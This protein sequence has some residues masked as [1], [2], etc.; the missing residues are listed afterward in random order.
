MKILKKLIWEGTKRKRR[1][2]HLLTERIV[3][4]EKYFFQYLKIKLEKLNGNRWG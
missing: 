4:I 3:N 1:E 2:K